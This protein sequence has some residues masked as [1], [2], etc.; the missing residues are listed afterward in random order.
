MI[1]ARIV[2]P[3]GRIGEIKA[4]LVTD[5]PE[6][7]GRRTEFIVTNN[8]DRFET[9]AVEAIRFHKGMALVKL[10]G[11][12]SINDAEELRNLYLAI[13]P[14]ERAGLAPDS[15]WLDDVIGLEAFT[16]TGRPLGKITE[17]LRSKANDVW[18]TDRAMVPA[19]KEF[20]LSVDLEA[21]KVIVKDMEGLEIDQT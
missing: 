10:K 16:D 20:I 17:I 19:L 3:F 13:R 12:N 5:Y 7:F 21:G 11:V 1:V 18:V 8:R 14:D 15:F 9:R 6:E 4:L 2:S